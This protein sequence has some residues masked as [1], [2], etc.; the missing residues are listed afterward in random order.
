MTDEYKR[1]KKSKVL[2]VMENGKKYLM[3]TAFSLSLIDLNMEAKESLKQHP[4][5]FLNSQK[6]LLNL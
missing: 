4:K 2:V 6:Q 1:K 3:H 5:C